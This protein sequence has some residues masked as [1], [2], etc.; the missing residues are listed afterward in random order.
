MQEIN[1]TE[2]K[3]YIKIEIKL[4]KM[5]SQVYTKKILIYGISL[6][7]ETIFID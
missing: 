6:D 5:Q 1:Y 4:V 2:K 3:K 7:I